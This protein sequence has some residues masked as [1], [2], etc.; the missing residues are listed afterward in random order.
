MKQIY[1]HS[2]YLLLF[3]LFVFSLLG[4]AQ[5]VSYSYDYAGN[6][7]SR[8]VVYIS[9]PFHVKTDTTAVK[10]LSKPIEDKIGDR[11]IKIHPNPTRGA[12]AI[13][14]AGGDT[15]EQLSITLYSAQGVQLIHRKIAEG[16][17]PVEMSAYAAGWYILRVSAGSKV[18][19]FKIIKQ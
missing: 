11:V 16:L 14:I 1:T 17:T 2:H 7:I 9:N 4:K 10:Q 13:D 3:F 19:E 18:T 12:L 5:T 8:K 15:N 6:R